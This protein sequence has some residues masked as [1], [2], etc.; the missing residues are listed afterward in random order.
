MQILHQQIG[1]YQ[2]CTE[3]HGQ[4]QDKG[5][6]HS[7]LKALLGERICRTGTGYHSKKGENHGY[8]H[9]VDHGP[10]HGTVTEQRRIGVKGQA[11]GPEE[12]R[13]CHNRRIAGNGLCRQMDKRQDAGK[14]QNHQN[15]HHQR[16]ADSELVYGSVTVRAYFRTADHFFFSL[17]HDILL[18]RSIRLR[19]AAS[20]ICPPQSQGAV[21]PGTGTGQLPWTWKTAHFQDPFHIC[22]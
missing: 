9:T 7:S 14:A 2:P 20:Q 22:K 18:P 3:V 12:H 10:H 6:K 1:R 16:V 21:L 17:S 13:F 11:L 15:K 19:P 5:K 8:P 4:H